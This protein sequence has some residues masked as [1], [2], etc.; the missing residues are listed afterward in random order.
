MRTSLFLLHCTFCLLR[1][2]GLLLLL[3][4]L[5]SCGGRGSSTP[6]SS[7]APPVAKISA[8]TS[9]TSGNTVNI[10]G[11]QSVDPEGSALTFH[12]Q[13]T[14]PL[15]AVNTE[16]VFFTAPS[17]TT[18]TTFAVTLT[19][20]DGNNQSHSQ[21][22]SLTI[23]PALSSASRPSNTTCLAGT[24]PDNSSGIALEPV[25]QQLRFAQPVA[26]KQ[27]P[28]K[29]EWYLAQ[30]SGEIFQ[31]AN[32]ATASKKLILDLSSIV[33][34]SAN[35]SG[36]LAFTF[37]PDFEQSGI[38]YTFYQTR[39]QGQRKSVLS[40]FSQF[41]INSRQDLITL[42]PP[43]S[44]H[45]GGELAFGPDGYL[46]LTIGDGGSG[47]DPGNR[48]QNTKNLF[49]TMIRLDVTQNNDDAPYGIPADNPFANNASTL[50]STGSSTQD[51]PEIYAWG[52]RNS[53]RFSFDMPTGNLW[54]A[55]V[56][57]DAYEEVNIIARG[58]NYGWRIKEATHCFNPRSNC[59]SAG[60]IDPVAEIKHPAGKSITG[61]HVYRG[62]AIA[63]LIGRY[64][65]SDYQSGQFWALTSDE[66]GKLTPVTILQSGYNIGHFGQDKQGELYVIDFGSGQILKLVAA[67]L[68]GT[69]APST[70]R[71]TGCV[72][73]NNS[74]QKAQGVIPYS[75]NANFWSDGATKKRFIA[76]PDDSQIDNTTS[77]WQWP[78]GTVLIKDFYW[79]EKLI[80]TRLFK[81][82]TNNTWAGY[83]YA[84][85][86]AQTEANLVEGGKVGAF[87]NPSWIYP[88][89]AQCLQCHT[90]ISG[91]VLGVNAA[92]LNK[93]TTNNINQLLQWQ[94]WDL[95][96]QPPTLSVAMTNPQDLNASLN[97]RARSYLD[98]NCAQ[99]H[100]PNGPT[101]VKMDLRSNTPLSA[102]NICN[103]K[104]TSNTLN[105]TNAQRLTPGST[106]NSMLYQRMNRRDLQAMPPMGSYAVD[107]EAVALIG[108]W[109]NSLTH[110]N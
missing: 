16:N 30:K 65:F 43:F 64:V 106:A 109:I 4:G 68:T 103:I 14:L 66:N 107:E 9:A 67:Q 74:T 101:N 51:C 2:L 53:W 32:A 73:T 86:E 83:S 96:T 108:E 93:N 38:L 60:L 24:K 21:T 85:N 47:G 13:S 44:N 70:L 33:D 12:W 1:T 82:H 29:D 19:V 56:G 99:C 23:T 57:Q 10:L 80:E 15:N 63:G 97:L 79:D 55:D 102:M 40:R 3:A 71:E 8:P 110:C 54:L 84:W 46:Y 90:Q 76:I 95:L 5:C 94:Q 100:Q 20:T 91:R 75:V 87:N 34:D 69:K 78:A 27:P 88:T 50:C 105:L 61:G 25:L 18:A 7:N 58:G 36:L 48:A 17:V 42:T 28:H 49:G 6:A 39:Q 81:R 26:L 89:G 59:N 31:F 11:E 77:Q 104:A 92:Q 37:A 98:T 41:D 52:L 62:S 45:F 22:I 72:K 35:E